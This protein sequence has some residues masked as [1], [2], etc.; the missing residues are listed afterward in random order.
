MFGKPGS[1]YEG[2]ELYDTLRKIYFDYTL[3]E[4]GYLDDVKYSHTQIITDEKEFDNS[5]PDYT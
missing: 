3:D 2:Q 1:K 5:C 4:K